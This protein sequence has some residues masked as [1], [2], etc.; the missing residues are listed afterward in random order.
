[1]SRFG[2]YLLIMISTSCIILIFLMVSMYINQRESIVNEMM[3]NLSIVNQNKSDEILNWFNNYLD[4]ANSIMINEYNREIIQSEL[5][6]SGIQFEPQILNIFE[7]YNISDNYE[8]IIMIDSSM[9]IIESLDTTMQHICQQ[10]ML[11][12]DEVK[13]KKMIMFSNFYKCSLGDRFHIDIVLPVI[14]SDRV[15][16]MIIFRINA[17]DKLLTILNTYSFYHESFRVVL[18]EKDKNGYL[19]INAYN[20]ITHTNFSVEF[21]EDTAIELIQN[22]LK[23]KQVDYRGRGLSGKLIFANIKPIYQIHWYLVSYVEQQEIMHMFLRESWLII[24]IFVIILSI[25]I[26]LYI[27]LF[28][29]RENELLEMKHRVENEKS[30]IEGKYNLLSKNANDMIMITDEQ[31]HIVEANIR[32][33]ARYGNVKGYK[34]ICIE[35]K[36]GKTDMSLTEG[37]HRDSN[38]VEFDVEVSSSVIDING[39]PFR[40]RVIRDI[41]KRKAAEQALE[42]NNEYLSA[43]LNSTPS[44]VFDMDVDARVKSLWNKKA[45]EL[46]GWKRH[47]VLGH[48]NPTVPETKHGEATSIFDKVMKGIQILN[49]ET[50]R[51]HKDG[52]IIDVLISAAP[53]YGKQG[54]PIGVIAVMNDIS[55]IIEQRNALQDSQKELQC[56]EE[57]LRVQLEKLKKKQE[58]LVDSYNKLRQLEFIIN[59]SPSI[60]ITWMLDKFWKVE[61]VS[62]NIK[63]LGI[64]KDKLLSGDVNYED[65]LHPDDYWRVKREIEKSFNDK[66]NKYVQEYRLVTPDGHTRWIRDYN[67]IRRDDKG[68]MIS[69]DGIIIDITDLK[70]IREEMLQS[71]KMDAIGQLA[72][73][74]AHDFNNLLGGIFG[75]AELLMMECKD[76]NSRTMI[77]QI[78]EISGRASGLTS[79]LL[80]FARKGR[81]KV[82]SFSINKKVK[83]TI[84]ILSRTLNRNIEV[85]ADYGEGVPQIS[86]DPV[87]IESV[88]LNIGINARDA[89]PNGGELTFRTVS[90]DLD[91]SNIY[92]LKSG[93]YVK[94]SIKDTGTG[95]NRDVLEHIFEPFFTTKSPKKGTGLGLS[96]AYGIIKNHRGA[97]NV[98]SEP[99]MGSEFIILIPVTASGEVLAEVKQKAIEKVKHGSGTVLI[100][101]DEEMIRNSAEM[102]LKKIGYTVFTVSSGLK[103]VEFINQRDGDIDV[104]LLDMIMPELGGRETYYRIMSKYPKSKIII[105]SGFSDDHI[106]REIIKAGARA[107]I[108]KPFSIKTL[109]NTLYTVINE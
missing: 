13:E 20:P 50:V 57:E 100:V 9:N 45:E 83:D 41:T 21:P 49:I 96:S 61:F 28:R 109:S 38:G 5:A 42:E 52:Q 105:S 64:D 76:D 3:D 91:D 4:D 40:I 79:Q 72:G 8:N 108:Q 94:I 17:S 63:Q 27:R 73:G 36:T 34:D 70:R 46:F 106:A 43:I 15:L 26:Y 103:A 86:G 2:K 80:N 90:L 77:E 14:E 56:I 53:I 37:K 92:N 88:L 58:E 55:E 24:S 98:F 7:S 68:A 23:D 62:N 11:V 67:Y 97:I 1:M 82:S 81:I 87:Q 33:L 107:F 101:D 19:L 39:E 22:G 32:A 104:I 30:F 31:E 54:N 65:Y 51:M 75:N 35:E 78:L 44:A 47:E 12:V 25:G 59:N 74:I 48:V 60:A 10:T 102:L 16:G 99:G 69:I 71:S 29:T 6:L 89:M 66:E 84:D 85:K 93:A 95:M 18:F